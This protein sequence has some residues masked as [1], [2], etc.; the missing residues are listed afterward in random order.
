MSSN[1]WLPSGLRL[2]AD[3]FGELLFPSHC[4]YCKRVGYWLCNSCYE[5]LA[6]SSAP[7]TLPTKSAVSSLQ[8]ALEYSPQAQALLHALKYPGAPALAKPCAEILYQAVRLPKTIT[9]T[10]VPGDPVRLRT[11]GFNQAELIARTFAELRSV[12]AREL[13]KKKHTTKQQVKTSDQKT[14]QK[15]LKKAFAPTLSLL[16]HPP[17]VVALIDDVTTT[18]TTLQECAQVLLLAG[19]QEVHGVTLAQVA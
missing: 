1:S 8:S 3:S 17:P 13:L 14:R 16:L 10:W 18:G 19:V 9:I 6:F 15:N 4:V 2:I 12:P 11:R 7:I 5:Q